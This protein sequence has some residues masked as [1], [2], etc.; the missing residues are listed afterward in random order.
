MM[1]F[2]KEYNLG[3]EVWRA[4]SKRVKAPE[5]FFLYTE[6]IGMGI[7]PLTR[8]HNHLSF[9]VKDFVGSYS[10]GKAY[11]CIMGNDPMTS[12]EDGGP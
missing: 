7:G 2:R 4:I 5:D 3:H 11:L 9:R 12:R 6:G 1:D 10:G 8:C